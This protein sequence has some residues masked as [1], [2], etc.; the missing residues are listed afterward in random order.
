MGSKVKIN[1]LLI[2]IF[3][4]GLIADIQSQNVEKQEVDSLW[5]KQKTGQLDYLEEQLDSKDFNYEFSAM[6][7]WFNSPFFK[8]GILIFITLVLLIVLYKLFGKGMFLNDMETDKT[9]AHLLTEN[10]L[11]DRFFEMDLNLMLKNAIAKKNWTMA[12]RI[13]YLM[14]LKMLIDKKHVYWHK[15]LTNR[16]LSLQIK[17][18]ESRSK[19]DELVGIFEKVWYG[20]LSIDLIEFEKV[21]PLFE[22]YKVAEKPDVEK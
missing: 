7:T 11:D 22:N 14:V 9:S 10:D 19:F 17:P 6:P 18:K 4:A 15:D 13:H 16:Q 2:C 8:Y 5:W 21:S 20:D 12:V 3:F 1:I